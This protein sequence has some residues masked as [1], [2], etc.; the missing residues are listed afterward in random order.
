VALSTREVFLILRARDEA[1]RVL[2][3]FGDSMKKLDKDTQAVVQRQIAH[4]QALSSVGIG[5]IAAGTAVT[6]FFKSAVDASNEY[7]RQAALTKTQTDKVKVSISELKDIGREVGA[8][9]PTDFD[10]IQTALYDIFSSIDVNLPQAK[11]LLH[12]FAMES[13][14]GQE[15]LQ[16]AGKGTIGILNSFKIPIKDVRTVSDTMFQLVRKGVG[17]YAQFNKTIGRAVPSAV[18]AGQSFQSLAGMMAFL[19]RNGI[20]A[21][22]ASASAGRALDAISNEKVVGRLEKMGIK[23]RDAAGEF[24]PMNKIMTQLG[25]KM[26]DM[27]GPERAAALND[28]FKG[29]GG[30]IQARRFFD[31]AVKNYAQLNQYTDAM[32]HSKGAMQ[33]AYDTMFKQPQSQAVL[34]TN[35]MK[36]L[37]TEIG[38]ALVPAW[39][40]ITGAVIKVVQWFNKLSPHTRKMIVRIAAIAAGVMILVGVIATVVGGIL[41]FTAALTAA[42]IT[43]GAFLGV[44]GIVVAAIVLL[45]V[46]I[47]LLVKYHKQ[48]WAFM[49]K[50]WFA[51]ADA[52]VAASQ[53]I[54]DAIKSAWSAIVNFFTGVGDAIVNALGS[55]WKKIVSDTKAVLTFIK[56]VFSAIGSFFTGIFN[57]VKNAVTTA[58]NAVIGAFKAVVNAV[59]VAINAIATVWG[60]I[61]DAVD[62]PVM[63]IL[64][65]LNEIWIR[66]YPIL[67]LPFYIALR[68]MQGIWKLIKDSFST[69]SDWAVKVWS[70]TWA[71]IEKYVADPLSRAWTKIKTYWADVKAAFTAAK[72]WVTN[73]W[74]KVWNN[75][76]NIIMVP[77]NLAKGYIKNRWDDIKNNFN[78][79]KNWVINSWSKAWNK[80][81][82]V[83]SGPINAAKDFIATRWTNIKNNFN[84]V[85]N[86]ALS[87]WSKS[88]VAIKNAIVTPID[89]AKKTLASILSAA[90]GGL[91]WVFTQA[92][93]GISRAWSTLK[94]KAKAPIRFIIDTVLN[95]GLIAGFNWIAN[96][97]QAP[98]IKP[99]PLPKGFASGGFFSGR[100]PGAPSAVDNMLGWA[101]NKAVGLASGEFIVN[102]R[103]TAKYLPWLKA[104]NG[105]GFA[106][107]GLLGSL[108]SAAGKAFSAGKSF[109]GGAADFLAN[110]G[111]WF[112]KRFAGPLGKLNQLG[113]SDVVKVVRKVPEAVGKL[114]T[115]KAKSVLKDMVGVPGGAGGP[116][117]GGSG[118]FSRD[119]QIL[120]AGTYT[121][122][123]KAEKM[124]GSMFHVMQGS[125]S[126]RVAASGSTHAGGGAMD[127]D[128]AGKGWDVAV[129]ILRAVGFAAWHR[130]PA[131]G[132]WGHHIHSIAIGDPLLSPS[133]RAQA[134]DF[135]RGGDGLAGYANGAWRIMR[136]QLAYLHKDEMVVP[137]GPA[138]L[139]RN[140]KGRGGAGNG[141]YMPITIHTQ[142]I[143][144]IKHAADLG[145]E[146]ARRVG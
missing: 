52:V 73:T 116:F 11:Q 91:Q 14:A 142:E 78:A 61:V 138:S 118:R 85:K 56:N 74:S 38:D 48:I 93:A 3:G 23:V 30:T 127:T 22:M 143:D 122:L 134:A 62:G 112:K 7:T 82:D 146:I 99:I 16:E 94:D 49:K 2:R 79:V 140:G 106:D 6:A 75:I 97:F 12:E 53:A 69:I 66:I 135:L 36:I 76:T 95:N 58:I 35:N 29:A 100:L 10:K 139:I 21:A 57:T 92:V 114:I 24:M 102:A 41:L 32:I 87:T 125:F 20:S 55:A 133:A 68:S 45:G 17:T 141:I 71:T 72:D 44:V 4:G 83:M 144:P 89:N 98:T 103:S 47:F 13:V 110:P 67:V 131:Q 113:S 101:K 88:W 137:K 15:D 130:T 126:T 43:L 123:L 81:K 1:T 90:K 111:D 80:V 54:W 119:G 18:R 19:T 33:E 109:V 26:K 37:K 5:L 42:G 77:I 104:M 129:R 40:A 115:D 121:M 39:L 8:K 107:G 9:V 105:D 27:T 120:D 28:L 124:L 46:V 60:K 108:K 31:L 86:W 25:E 51:I 64:K 65:I 132:P 128:N 34:L 59:G 50:V 63:A 136:N 145:W 84:A 117:P 70:K 96:K